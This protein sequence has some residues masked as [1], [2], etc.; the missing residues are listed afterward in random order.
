MTSSRSTNRSRRKLWPR[1]QA[2]SFAGRDSWGRRPLGPAYCS[3]PR[4]GRRPS[5]SSR[6]PPLQSCYHLCHWPL[7]SGARVRGSRIK[8][9]A[10]QSSIKPNTSR[11]NHRFFKTSVSFWPWNGDG[12]DRP[13]F[14]ALRR[15]TKS[16]NA[17]GINATGSTMAQ[18]PKPQRH[19]EVSTM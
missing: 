8:M 14:E 16:E 9:T 12:T 18:R 5:T 4:M 11:S 6:S 13:R 10:A 15:F 19:D 1:R 17:S 2:R 3:S 7:A